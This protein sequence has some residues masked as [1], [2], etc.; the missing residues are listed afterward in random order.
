MRSKRS[1]INYIAVSNSPLKRLLRHTMKVAG[2]SGTP[3][4]RQAIVRN[5][6]P[7]QRLMTET[8]SANIT[9]PRKRRQPEPTANERTS[10]QTTQ[11]S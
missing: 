9:Q 3:D 7:Q 4:D 5:T 1:I 8:S 10:E 2:N 11:Q 6:K